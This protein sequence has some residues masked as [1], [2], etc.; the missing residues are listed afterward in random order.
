MFSIT[1]GTEH[2]PACLRLEGDLTIYQVSEARDALLALSLPPATH[3]Q[4]DLAGLDE[5]DS[6]G[7]QL[8][9]ALQQ[10]LGNTDNPAQVIAAS[11]AARELFELLRLDSLYAPVVCED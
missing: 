10:W 5:I 11:P 7:A 1:P 8:L 9:L 6:A 3:W 4:L 2:D